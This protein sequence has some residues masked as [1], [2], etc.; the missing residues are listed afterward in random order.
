MPAWP[1]TLPQDL[2]Q[3]GYSQALPDNV[4][5]TS[6]DRG[7]EQRRPRFTSAV[8]PLSGRMIM[9]EAQIQ[10]LDTWFSDDIAYGALSFTFPNPM[11]L[12][13]TST[14]SVVFAQPPSWDNSPGGPKFDVSLVM[15]IQP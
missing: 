3:S 9:T 15:E 14:I 13:G 10:T 5:K 12:T 11:D 7:P 1:T 6:V 2:L 4:I 8:A